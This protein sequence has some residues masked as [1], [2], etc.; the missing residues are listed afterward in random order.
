M[1]QM[2]G[3]ATVSLTWHMRHSTDCPVWQGVVHFLE[4]VGLLCVLKYRLANGELNPRLML[5]VDQDGQQED[6]T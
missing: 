3:H 1:Q 4:R 5:P 6:C 2:N